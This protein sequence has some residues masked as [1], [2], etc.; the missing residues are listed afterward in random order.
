MDEGKG[1]GNGVRDEWHLLDGNSLKSRHSGERG[2]PL[3][4][5]YEMG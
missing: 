3:T 2:N 5:G 4:S 1:V